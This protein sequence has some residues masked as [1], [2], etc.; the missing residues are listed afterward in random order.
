MVLCSLVE[1]RLT[2]LRR[3]L[4]VQNSNSKILTSSSCK[5][6]T[7]AAS[8]NCKNKASEDSP[9]GHIT[10]GDVTKPLKKPANP[11]LVPSRYLPKDE[12]IPHETLKHMK[13]IMQKDLLG[14]DIF[15]I[16]RPSPLRRQVAMQYLQLT[17][18]EVEYVA[19]SRDTTESDLKQ[20]REIILGTAHYIDQSAVRAASQGRILILEGIEKA[21]R[22]VLPVLNNLL[23][24]R[25]MHLEDGRL[26][27]P[28]DRY[29][30]LLKEYGRKS[31]KMAIS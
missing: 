16:G 26:L 22:N 19:L 31:G 6:W 14:Q 5:L 28:A 24:N 7:T 20:R 3:I 12:E 8:S 13:W 25:E 27:I 1:G 18:R 10:I 21:E 23:E 11:E 29:D 30:K 4:S 2:V 9:S 15:L 17:E